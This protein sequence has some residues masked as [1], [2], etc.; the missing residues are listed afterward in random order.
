MLF[1]TWCTVFYTDW[2]TRLPT[3]FTYQKEAPYQ[4]SQTI[5]SPSSSG[6]WQFFSFLR[7]IVYSGWYLWVFNEMDGKHVFSCHSTC[8]ISL[9][10]LMDN[11]FCC[12]HV[13]NLGFQF[14]I[15]VL[16]FN[17]MFSWMYDG[18]LLRLLNP[19]SSRTIKICATPNNF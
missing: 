1:D 16:T 17:R 15:Q 5:M 11:I 2:P 14:K 18:E 19:F 3:R 10:T 4:I 12:G 8:E 13:Q 6:T 7:S 9:A